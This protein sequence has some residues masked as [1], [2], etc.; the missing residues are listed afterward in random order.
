MKDLIAIGAL[1]VWSCQTTPQTPKLSKPDTIHAAI[2]PPQ[3]NPY[4]SDLARLLGGIRPNDT[5]YWGSILRDS[6]WRS[7][8]AEVE[9]LWTFRK[10]ALYDS[11][12]VWAA[13][14][15][16]PYHDWKGRVFYPFSGA[17][18][19]TVF[20]IY[21]KGSSYIF[22]GLEQE[23]DPHYLR[24]LSPTDIVQNLRGPFLTLQDL[25]RLSFFKTKDMQVQLAHGKVRGL[26][27]VFL[28]LFARTGHKI[29]TVEHIYLKEG[30]IIDT[31]PSSKPKPAQSAW[32]NPIT[33]LR[34]QI[35]LP[36][37]PLQE[38]IYLSLNAANT[39]IERQVGSRDFLSRLRPCVSLI[40]S[41]SYLLFG[42]DFSEIR[43]LILTQS[44]AILEEDSGIPFR[45]FDSTAWK[46][47]LYGV[48]HQPIPL[49]RSKFQPD[50]WKAYRTYPVKRLPFTI[51]YHIMPGQSNLIWA[52]RR[53]PQA[54]LPPLPEEATQTSAE[55]I[56]PLPPQRLMYID[57]SLPLSK[58]TSSTPTPQQL[59]S[60]EVP[61]GD[62][63]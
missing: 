43:R 31:L 49:F 47:Q 16:S 1:F 57:T 56:T 22:F 24:M 44:V 21:P 40:K 4:W 28:A 7:Y 33:G 46:T 32:D 50:L 27:P 48:Y 60:T 25:L 13:Q 37:G 38:V 34:F 52:V 63:E 11:L 18:W 30:G 8:A 20:Y 3:P 61:S 53:D 15:L 54:V 2:Q 35:G 9:R 10:K 42:R 23:G 58:D 12:Q 19:P 39:G 55:R 17:D 36:E 62:S 14:E 41:A 29:Y 51:G 59:D 5:L 6:T 26:L 45:F